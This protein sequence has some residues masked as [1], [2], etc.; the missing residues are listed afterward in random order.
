MSTAVSARPTRRT[1][2]RG[3]AWSVPVVALAATA[4]AFAASTAST[5]FTG[6]PGTAEKWGSG[7]D[8]HVSWDLTI[9]NGPVAID[10]ISILFTYTPKNS[11]AFKVLEIYGYATGTPTPPSRDLGWTYPP[12]PQ[13][14]GVYS[15]T[16]THLADIPANTTYL[17]H[18]DFSGGDNA[19][20]T[21]EALAT[22]KYVGSTATVTKIIAPLDWQPGNQHT[23]HPA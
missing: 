13:T 4:P 18:T 23:S 7:Q 8:K 14:T 21:V 3:A 1:L 5:G 11:G 15:I 20:G 22:I 9:A 16:A 10:E 19:A 2:V 6:V 12:I 17:L